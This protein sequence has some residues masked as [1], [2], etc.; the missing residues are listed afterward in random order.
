[1]YLIIF[2][3]PSAQIGPIVS[4]NVFVLSNVEFQLA[5]TQVILSIYINGLETNIFLMFSNSSSMVYSR[6]FHK[7]F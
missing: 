4:F 2:R 1:M 7:T 3:T 6:S 5:N